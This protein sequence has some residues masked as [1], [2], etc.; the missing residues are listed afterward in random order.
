MHSV[1]GAGAGQGGQGGGPGQYGSQV[2]VGGSGASRAPKKR[3]HG[4]MLG[5][6]NK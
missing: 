5:G 1:S 3:G 4:G 2:S 6:D